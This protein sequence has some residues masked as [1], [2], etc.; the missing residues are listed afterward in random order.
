MESRRPSFG[1]SLVLWWRQLF[2]FLVF[3]WGALALFL[4]LFVLAVLCCGFFLVV[5]V[6]VVLFRAVAFLFF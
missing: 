1:V 2:G 3:V 4:V 5:V 6:V